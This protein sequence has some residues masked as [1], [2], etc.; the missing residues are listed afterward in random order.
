MGLV[1]FLV[2]Y[3]SSHRVFPH[4]DF[5]ASPSGI[6]AIKPPQ[7]TVNL[8]SLLSIYNSCYLQSLFTLIWSVQTIIKSVTLLCNTAQRLD[9]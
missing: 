5:R 2:Y 6:D 8:W 7:V 9:V 3:V 1:E 4:C